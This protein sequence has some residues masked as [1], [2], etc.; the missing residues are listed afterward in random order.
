MKKSM[1]I[2]WVALTSLG[3]SA[4]GFMS[5]SG[6]QGEQK[7]P[8]TNTSVFFASDLISTFDKQAVPDLFYNVGSRFQTTITKEKPEPG[9]NH[10]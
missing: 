1:I 5:W 8:S 4:F 7:K 10:I 6:E 2:F 9:P 3:I